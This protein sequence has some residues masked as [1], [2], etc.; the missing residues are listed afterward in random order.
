MDVHVTSSVQEVLPRLP[1]TISAPSLA[2]VCGIGLALRAPDVRA[3][4]VPPACTCRVEVCVGGRIC[5]CV[6]VHVCVCVCVV[7]V[8]VCICVVN[9][10]DYS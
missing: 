7:C 3:C 6:C 1:R 9:G 4:L 8:C 10:L 2:C 5:M